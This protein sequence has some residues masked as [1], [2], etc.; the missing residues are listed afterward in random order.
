MQLT[1]TESKNGLIDRL[2]VDWVR[3]PMLK[4][5]GLL[6]VGIT[7]AG[8]GWCFIRPE[9]FFGLVIATV[10]GSGSVICDGNWRGAGSGTLYTMPPGAAHG[11]KARD[12]GGGWKY[13]WAMFETTDRYPEVFDNRN[14]TLISAPSYSLEAANRGLFAEVARANDPQLVGI[15]CD[16][17]RASLTT[18]V[19]RANADPRLKKLWETVTQQLN[20]DWSIES[21]AAQ[22]HIG[23]EHL[24]RLCQR[25]YGRSPHQ[26]LTQLRLRKACELLLLSGDTLD[27]VASQIGF[28]DAFSFSKAFTREY[29]I[30]PSKYRLKA[31]SAAR[32]SVMV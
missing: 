1:K 29:G 18:L 9:P 30:P 27:A 15:W 28:S 22:A 12:S 2:S 3:C 23:R 13:A 5:L 32:K 6:E 8:N 31:Q 26:R 20:A 16:L 10:S 25:D 4:E 19:S 14:A 17:I 11:Y 7:H 24:R 21:L